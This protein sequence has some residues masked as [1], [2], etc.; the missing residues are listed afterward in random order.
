VW[1]FGRE[2][3]QPV[4]KIKD[5]IRGVKAKY[6]NA[7]ISILA[8]SYGTVALMHALVDPT[9]Q[10]DRVILCGSIVP[11]NGIL[12]DTFCSAPRRHAS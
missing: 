12:K 9:I 11:S 4:Q 7:R 3:S 10:V 1:P 2:K 5:E 6:K 8:H